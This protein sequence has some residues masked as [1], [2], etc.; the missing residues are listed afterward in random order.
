MHLI[1]RKLPSMTATILDRQSDLSTDQLAEILKVRPQTIRAAYCRAGEY[2]G[3]TP[4]KMPNR[5][6]VWDSAAVRALLE[7]SA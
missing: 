3:L 1:R 6:L 2:F 7:R 5:R 4:C